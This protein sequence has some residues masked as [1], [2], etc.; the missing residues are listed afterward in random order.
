[1]LHWACAALGCTLH[2]VSHTTMTGSADAAES[3]FGLNVAWPTG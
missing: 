2:G 1:M 3:V